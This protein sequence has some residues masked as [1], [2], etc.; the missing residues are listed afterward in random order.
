MILSRRYAL[1]LSITLGAELN[2]FVP[3]SCSSTRPSSPLVLV[4]Q[5]TQLCRPSQIPQFLRA[6][7]PKATSGGLFTP[8]PTPSARHSLCLAVH[9]HPPAR[10]RPHSNSLTRRQLSRSM[11]SRAR[12]RSLR[13]TKPTRP[14]RTHCRQSP[15]LA[16][17]A[18]PCRT[19]RRQS[20]PLLV[21]RVYLEAVSRTT[22]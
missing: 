9:L 19:A 14:A 4:V 16:Q 5:C 12:R 6:P 10:R 1:C 20:R 3:R 22:R 2:V 17:Q 13:A 8:H 15:V 21:I 7:C 11:V 18:R